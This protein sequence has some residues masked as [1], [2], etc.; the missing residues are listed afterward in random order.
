MLLGGAAYFLEGFDTLTETHLVMM[1]FDSN[2]SFILSG[3]VQWF[4]MMFNASVLTTIYGVAIEYR[5]LM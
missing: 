1:V 4:V 2:I 3:L 5:E